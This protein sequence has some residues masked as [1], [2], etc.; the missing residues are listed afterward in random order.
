MNIKWWPPQWPTQVLGNSYLTLSRD[1]SCHAGKVVS[2]LEPSPRREALVGVLL[3]PATA[4][5]ATAAP[6]GCQSTPAAA[7]A[8]A[9]LSSGAYQG[10]L[11]LVPLDPRLPKGLLAPDVV[12]GL[13]ET[14]RWGGVGST[15][16]SLKDYNCIETAVHHPA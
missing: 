2:I 1:V 4:M 6:A 3:P 14:L 16:Y 5:R 7:A 15:W 9:A 10:F 12:A 11:M 13:P 8:A